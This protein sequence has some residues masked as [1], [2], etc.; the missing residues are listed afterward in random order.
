MALVNAYIVHKCYFEKMNENPP[1]HADYLLHVQAQL[2]SL[3]DEDF[4]SKQMPRESTDTATESAY[5][6]KV[7]RIAH[8]IRQ[9]DDR[10]RG[11]SKPRTRVCKVCGV[12]SDGRYRKHT[13]TTYCVE[14]SD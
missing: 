5:V 13:T 2:L 8:S 14:C 6:P 4:A 10:V 7:Q 1:S 9:T 3:R 11:G 12:L